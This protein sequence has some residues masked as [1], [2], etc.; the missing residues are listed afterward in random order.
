M[1]PVG[2]RQKNKGWHIPGYNFCGPFTNLLDKEAV[3]T[4]DQACKQHDL[5]FGDITVETGESD[6]RLIDK[7]GKETGIAAYLVKTGI[8]IKH[9][10][11]EHT[12]YYSDNILRPPE[13]MS[14][15]GQQ[16]W[17]INQYYQNKK[18]K[19]DNRA[20][21]EGT[22]ADTEWQLDD[23]DE[24]VLAAADVPEV[25]AIMDVETGQND[26][27]GGGGGEGTGANSGPDLKMGQQPHRYTR[28]F[29]RSYTSYVQ[30]GVSG[31][32]WTPTAGTRTRAPRIEWCEGFQV[33][34]WGILP[35]HLSAHDFYELAMAKKWRIKN[36]AVTVDSIIPFQSGLFGGGTTRETTTTFSNRP[37]IQVYVDDGHL[38]PDS[39]KV[40]SGLLHNLN[41]TVP[42]GKISESQLKLMSFTFDNV[43]LT[44]WTLATIDQRPP[45]TR[46]QQ[47]FSLFN[48]GRVMSLYPGDKFHRSWTNPDPQWRSCRLTNDTVPLNTAQGTDDFQY[49]TN[50]HEVLTAAYDSGTAARGAS[51][52]AAELNKQTFVNQYA[53]TGYQPPYCAPP[54]I[55][56]KME[57]YYGS[58]DQPLELFAQV[59]I[60][61]H[62]TV[63]IEEHEGWGGAYALVRPDNQTSG[64]LTDFSRTVD[65]HIAAFPSD[66][67][68]DRIMG[69]NNGTYLYS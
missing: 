45:E 31:A 68:F 24:E 40:I 47:V 12:N 67:K 55:L 61:Y 33:L 29:K 32:K 65:R 27:G 42:Y 64:N 2:A 13:Y 36:I 4:L 50:R 46:P 69:P 23:I 43:D 66:N 11:D 10:I 17:R 37:S 6:L 62:M 9:W 28:T 39:T 60:H 49:L 22:S 14:K 25:G 53:D 8:S 26:S 21:G 44:R 58:N 5:E 56:M 38:L 51:N 57:T 3:N 16:A 48:T 19:E 7:A 63:E 30:N 20:A 18:R 54:Y 34:P 15:R 52:V 1:P 35:M 59:H 41:G